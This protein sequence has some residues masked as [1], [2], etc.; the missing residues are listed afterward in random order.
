[1]LLDVRVGSAVTRGSLLGT[2]VGG[3]DGDERALR[4]A[5]TIGEAQPSERPLLVDAIAPSSL[6]STSATR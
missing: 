3:E 5:F 4:A 2:V 6:R 1:M